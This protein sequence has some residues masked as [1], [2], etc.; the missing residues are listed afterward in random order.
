MRQVH[1]IITFDM[2]RCKLNFDVSLQDSV[3]HNSSKLKDDKQTQCVSDVL[4]KIY[5]NYLRLLTIDTWFFAFWVRDGTEV[6]SIK[7]MKGLVHDSIWNVFPH[8]ILWFF[9]VSHFEIAYDSDDILK[10]VQSQYIAQE[11]VDW[12]WMKISC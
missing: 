9:E 2:H 7:N 8:T 10:P 11:K 3:I 12:L 5:Y 6:H 1:S 4:N